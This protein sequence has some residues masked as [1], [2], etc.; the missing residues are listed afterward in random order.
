MSNSVNQA[1]EQRKELADDPHRPHSHF[2]PP[3]NWM[4]D[5]NGLIHWKGRYHLFYQHNPHGAFHEK[6]HWGH[7]LSSDLVHW[8]DLPIALTPTPGRADADGCWSG[9]AIDN[10]GTPTLLYTGILPRLSA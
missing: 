10:H 9:C 6:I 1:L 7:A 5:P 8:T 2:L 4:N 3:A